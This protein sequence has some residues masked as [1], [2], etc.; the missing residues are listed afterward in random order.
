LAEQRARSEI[1]GY[2]R[3]LALA[4]QGT[5]WVWDSQ[6]STYRNTQTGEINGPRQILDLR[7]AYIENVKASVDE[8]V[9][10]L[11]EGSLSIQE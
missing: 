11:F 1:E 7:D 8:S 10:G 4:E 6:R 5:T 2:L 3:E 9:N